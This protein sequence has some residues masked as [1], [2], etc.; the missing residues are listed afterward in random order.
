MTDADGQ[1]VLVKNEYGDVEGT[2]HE[3]N[4]SSRPIL[5]RSVDSLLAQQSNI[6]GVSEIL[7]GC[8]YVHLLILAFTDLLAQ[9]MFSALGAD[10]NR[11][12]RRPSQSVLTHNTGAAQWSA[13]S[14]TP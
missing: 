2:Y 5:T 8:L 10:R 3:P 4:E 7:N 14:R 12:T 11:T 9:A 1:V 6:T 13:W